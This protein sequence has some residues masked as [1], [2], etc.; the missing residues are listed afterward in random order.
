MYRKVPRQW[1]WK[2][3]GTM[4]SG[5]HVARTGD[6]LP[7]L[8]PMSWCHSPSLGPSLT[9]PWGWALT[10]LPL[11]QLPNSFPQVSPLPIPP[12]RWDQIHHTTDLQHRAGPT[13]GPQRS[14]LPL[15]LFHSPPWAETPPK[16][17]NAEMFPSQSQITQL[18][19]LRGSGNPPN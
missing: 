3:G 19:T 7:G 11:A 16:A 14:L 13:A 8:L 10:P 1:T 4:W 5:E 6:K 12:S 17:G 9:Q 15:W 2:W 18:M